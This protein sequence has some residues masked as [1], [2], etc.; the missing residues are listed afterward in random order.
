MAASVLRSSK[1]RDNFQRLARLSM[2]GGT[3]L[4]REVF[5]MKCP[6]RNL[7]TILQ[8]PHTEELLEGARLS[9]EEWKCLYPSSRKYGKSRDFDITLLFR[10][11]RTIC[12]LTPPK[13]GW[14][15]L[16]ASTDD[17]LKA[18]LARIK[19]YRNK[20]YHTNE[21]M[22]ISDDKF[23]V[24]WR[25]IS[26]TLVRV[27][28][29][30]SRT[31][32]REWKNAIRK[33]LKDPLTEKDKRYKLELRR[34]YQNDKEVMEHLKDLDKEIKLLKKEIELLKKKVG[35]EARR[36]RRKEKSTAQHI[37]KCFR[38]GLQDITHRSEL[39]SRPNSSAGG[40]LVYIFCTYFTSKVFSL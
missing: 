20:I 23:S 15:A 8:D 12:D 24:L 2:G 4:L 38:Q 9:K 33:F 10:L 3:V 28:G 26:E 5:D 36:I 14:D 32:A 34:W 27:A 29:K 39:V 17:S 22:K 1:E 19:Y 13:T 30:I 16:P 7:P 6:P 18:D 31:K 35:K 40:Q 11:L 21:N 25:E 37:V